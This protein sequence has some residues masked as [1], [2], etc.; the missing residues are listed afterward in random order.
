MI[1]RKRRA[2]ADAERAVNERKRRYVNRH[3]IPLA[4]HRASRKVRDA[5]DISVK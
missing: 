3:V 1:S 5:R 4:V 2:L